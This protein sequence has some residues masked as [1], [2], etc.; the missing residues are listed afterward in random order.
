MFEGSLG[1]VRKHVPEP[2]GVQ[3]RPIPL[4][5]WGEINPEIMAENKWLILLIGVS[6]PLITS[7]GPTL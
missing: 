2:P 6:T 3:G 4:K 5:K 7:R 1:F